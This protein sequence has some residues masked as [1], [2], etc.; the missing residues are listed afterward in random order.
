MNGERSAGRSP[1]TD[2]RLRGR[3][4]VVASA[5]PDA[6]TTAPPPVSG[7]AWVRTSSGEPAEHFFRRM[8]GAYLGGA[9]GI[10]IRE[11]PRISSPTRSVVETFVRRTRHLSVHADDDRAIRLL[12]RPPEKF[13][14]LVGRLH[15]LGEQVVRFH[16]RAVNQWTR[17]P[18]RDE[19]LWERWDDA[20]DRDAWYLQRQIALGRTT[21][22][23]A[24][25]ALGL[26]TV[27]HALERAAD[28]AVVLGRAGSS[29]AELDPAD[30]RLQSLR[31][32]HHQALTHLREA[33]GARDASRANELLDVGEAL[34]VSAES[35]S[36]GLVPAGRAGALPFGAA[37]AVD[38]VLGAI[39]GVV[40]CSQEIAQAALDRPLGGAVR[41]VLRSARS[42]P[43]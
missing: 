38:R 37:V 42:L 33:L 1:A 32:L 20:I 19:E 11:R 30:G 22:G 6:W 25:R 36:E 35:I 3:W 41:T 26:W 39:A 31:Q 23:A 7:L 13:E 18:L 28:R 43:N 21:P 24:G 8:L 40:N 9:E 2:D 15:D 29:L 5:G 34:L 17:F 12:D 27:A 14:E 16:R 10:E 4:R